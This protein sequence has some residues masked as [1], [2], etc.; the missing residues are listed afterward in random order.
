MNNEIK[1]SIVLGIDTGLAIMG[2][3]VVQ[4]KSGSFNNLNLM[5][6]GSVTTDSKLSNALRLKAIYDATIELIEK[7]KPRVM[8]IESLFY[9][10]NQKTVIKVSQA[11]GVILLAAAEKGLLIYDYTPLQVKTSVTGYGRADKKQVQKMIT[12]IYGLKEDP[13]PDD[14]ADAIAVATCHIHTF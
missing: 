6:Y 7:F 13:K 5:G 9:F 14:V 4:K 11:R 8:A 3:S 2:W 1:N 10:K 12:R